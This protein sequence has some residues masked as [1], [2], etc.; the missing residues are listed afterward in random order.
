MQE[1]IRFGKGTQGWLV[2]WLVGWLEFAHRTLKIVRAAA[3][4]EKS[5]RPPAALF[6][7]T[8]VTS[9]RVAP[10]PIR[11]ATLSS[12]RFFE[13]LNPCF[14]QVNTSD[15]TFDEVYEKKREKKTKKGCVNT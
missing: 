1:Q 2:G 10:K 11:R 14:T 13:K 3:R 7:S 6:D 8:R 4:K 12:G 15:L 9:H 5:Q